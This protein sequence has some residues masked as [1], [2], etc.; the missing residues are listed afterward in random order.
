[1]GFLAG[2]GNTKHPTKAGMLVS[3]FVEDFNLR[4]VNAMELS[5]GNIHT[6]EC[7][8]GSSMIDY[9]LVPKY[10][11]NNILT[12]HTGRN[13]E[14]NTSDHVPIEVTLSID[15]LPRR[16]EVPTHNVRLKWEIFSEGSIKSDYQDYINEHTSHL[17]NTWPVHQELTPRNIDEGFEEM[18]RILH[19]AAGYIPRAKYVKHLKPYWCKELDMLKKSKMFW[20]Q[21]WKNEG[22]TRDDNDETRQK[23]KSTKKAF[24]K[25]LRSLE[26]EYQDKSI[27][28]AAKYAEVDRDMFWR[29]M[30]RYKK[31]TTG[32]INAIK[33]AQGK[34]V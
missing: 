32:G 12:C 29:C 31:R 2:P 3:K 4:V 8:N 23:M 21:I 34:V 9:V 5:T 13:E 24:I 14:A 22:R 20:F 11:D 28:Q 15:M 27:A 26:R 30:S 6:F 1:M 7:H 16:V 18:S 17:T 19:A 33:N 25:C 10:M